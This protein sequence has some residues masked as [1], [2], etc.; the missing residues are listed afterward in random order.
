MAVAGI[1]LYTALYSTLVAK[2]RADRKGALAHATAGTLGLIYVTLAAG[3]TDL[4][5]AMSLG[6][7]S[8][9]MIQV[10]R[11]PNVIAEHHSLRAALGRPVSL[12]KVPDSLYYTAWRLRRF[13]TDFHMFNMLDWLSRPLYMIKNVRL[14]K[15]QQWAATTVGVVLAGAP[16]TGLTEMFDHWLMDLL[17]EHPIAA[18]GA[19]AVHFTMSVLIIRFLFVI[20]LSSRR[21]VSPAN[22]AKKRVLE[23]K[24]AEKAKEIV[25]SAGTPS[26]ATSFQ[27]LGK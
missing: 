13:D 20:V 16:F 3:Y 1:G 23:A 5:L 12:K 17:L 27:K 22:V 15:M 8:F 9:R 7:A 11:S 14:T 24:L 25:G 2:I 18:V 26:A 19:M 6:H 21:F 4:A 10:L